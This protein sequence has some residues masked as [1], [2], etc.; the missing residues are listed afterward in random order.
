MKE[1]IMACKISLFPKKISQLFVSD[2]LLFR[3]LVVAERFLLEGLFKDR[4]R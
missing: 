4:S 2:S 3:R 1:A